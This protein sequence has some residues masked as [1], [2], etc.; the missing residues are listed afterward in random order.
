MSDSKLMTVF[1]HYYSRLT[2]VG[3]WKLLSQNRTLKSYET[4]DNATEVW[5]LF[6]AMDD[7]SNVELIS[8]DPEASDWNVRLFLRKESRVV[9]GA[10]AGSGG[11]FLRYRT[12]DV[13]R[14]E[15]L[16]VQ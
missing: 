16:Q 7:T 4:D 8:S 14:E 10:K 9:K 3:N 15:P 5:E 2:F 6:E 11:K 1:D 12:E 13:A